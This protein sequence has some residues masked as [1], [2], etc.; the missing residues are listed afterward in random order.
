MA[1]YEIHIQDVDNILDD[2]VLKYAE[3]DAIE[4]NWLGG[5]SKTQ[6]IVG[7]EL[8]FS[9]E[10][11]DAIDAAYKELFTTNEKKWLVSKRLSET[12]DL[13]WQGYVLPE[14]YAEP[15]RNGIFYV[16][17]SAVDGLGL[18]KGEKLPGDF[19]NQEKSVIEVICA[20]LKL[21]K[22]DLPLYFSPAIINSNEPDW[23]KIYVDTALFDKNKDNAYELLKDL[24]ESLRCQVYQC[25]ARWYVEGFNKKQL[26]QVS[27]STYNL[28]A[29][30]L[31]NVVVEKL[32]KQIPF[33]AEPSVTIV[34]P[35][36]QTEVT[37]P[38]NPLSFPKDI[39]K[40]N[41]VPW[42]ITPGTVDSI[43]LPKNWDYTFLNPLNKSIPEIRTINRDLVYMK[44]SILNELDTN[45]FIITRDKYYVEKNTVL[46]LTMK[47]E[48]YTFSTLLDEW[49][50]DTI[51]NTWAT[52]QIYEVRLDGQ[53]IHTNLNKGKNDPEYLK[54]DDNGK[55][56]LELI[57]TPE[58]SGLLDL[59]FYE[60]Y[61]S[62]MNTRYRGT[63]FKA[64]TLST[65]PDVS[66][67]FY[68]VKN[69]ETASIVNKIE[70][71]FGD[72]V[73]QFTNA[74]YLER[75]REFDPLFP[76]RFWFEVKYYEVR[77]GIT[78][79]IV[80]LRAAVMAFR[81]EQNLNRILH[82][83]SSSTVTG[84]V[85]NNPN[86]IF[87]FENG[88]S[89]AIEVNEQLASGH[90]LILYGKYKPETQSR[91]LNT[92]WSD[93][94]FEVQ[95]KRYG[96]VVA[97]I[98]NKI[99]E[100]PH[101]SFEGSTDR[102][103]KFNDIIKRFYDNENR[104][105]TISDLSWR[106]DS[107]TSDFIA[108]EM[109]YQGNNSE[110]L[111]PFV[112]AGEDITISLNQNDSFLSAVA[113]APS[114]T[115]DLIVWEQIDNN[116]SIT[117][118]DVNS[119][120]TNINNLTEDVYS[121]RITVTDSNG[122]SAS[123]EVNV[124]R[125]GESLLNLNLISFDQDTDVEFGLF[126]NFEIQYQVEIVPSIA[127]NVSLAVTFDVLLL[128][129]S[130]NYQNTYN[131]AQVKITKNNVLIFDYKADSGDMDNDTLS[132]LYEDAVFSMSQDDVVIIDLIS[133][134]EVFDQANNE[135]ADST[136]RITLKSA[137][138]TGANR[139][140]TNL[141]NSES[142]DTDASS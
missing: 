128:L 49:V 75:K 28:E 68:E 24:L 117:F 90:I 58:Q 30:F 101:F 29:T 54:F 44:P 94:I 26:L 105:F 111:P 129:F 87:N 6:P 2:L 140:I 53:V 100:T 33:L 73:T 9:L 130:N 21:T 83:N 82:V 34:P 5:E 92:E 46:Q 8:N 86:I 74:F 12:Q 45:K 39:V 10:S 131:N 62:F 112:D 76:N 57:I 43:W 123:D 114:G 55:C 60:P 52:Q 102:P 81:I 88:E 20:I 23:S 14:S 3:R 1:N 118:S 120:Q 77:N 25:D 95:K 126:D 109:L 141:P 63:Q 69:N 97:E 116:P 15:Y 22:I 127:P 108:N 42:V 70:L 89:A 64:L 72:D 17:I 137:E 59:K 142:A 104:F 84:E 125:V 93:A 133:N 67:D 136:A 115:I 7:S 124:I 40:E 107:N 61:G 96:Q 110:I 106:P 121:F 135:Q 71:R 27:Y 18:L 66:D 37:Y 35:I 50:T 19:Y 132:Q 103:L 80:P 78:Y 11:D 113:S 79:A 38:R 16:S 4:L 139:I 48:V 13:I 138:F 36:K 85:L 51:V 98:E 91:T 134:T 119:L 32:I 122:L 56:D 99:Y 47:L 65:D 31:E 41:S